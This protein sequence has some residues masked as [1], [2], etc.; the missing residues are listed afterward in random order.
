MSKTPLRSMTKSPVRL[1]K[2]ALR[3]AEKSIPWY[4]SKFS[5]KDFTQPQLFAILVLKQFFKTDYRGIVQLLKDWPEL[6]NLLGLK[7]VPCHGTVH[8]A[9][10][11]FLKKDIS[12]LSSML[13]LNVHENA[14]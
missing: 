3:I 4:S 9:D 8:N 7:K 13:S 5:K 2:L 14:A 1:A 12:N 11:R 6:Q 10:R